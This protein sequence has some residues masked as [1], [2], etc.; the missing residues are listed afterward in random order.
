M[1]YKGEISG[2]YREKGPKR[3]A[4]IF[5]LSIAL[6]FLSLLCATFLPSFEQVVADVA[7]GDSQKAV[8]TPESSVSAANKA[9]DAAEPSRLA[10]EKRISQI[11]DVLTEITKT[12]VRLD[13]RSYVNKMMGRELVNNSRI[14][15]VVL[16]V[17]AV[18]FPVSMWLL[19]KKRILGLSGLSSE[20]ATTLLAVEERQARLANLLKEL[21]DELEMAHAHPTS[22][23]PA[24]LR[25]LVEQA[26]EYLKANEEDLAKAGSE[27]KTH[28]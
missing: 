10:L 21:Q 20:V 13:E 24:Q 25:S 22:S 5:I 11:E 23:S 3:S 7:G 9:S 27:P 28:K 14:M 4:F 15:V 1:M 16:I 18:S 19:S 17:I 8:K 2:K 12:S 6:V 26:E